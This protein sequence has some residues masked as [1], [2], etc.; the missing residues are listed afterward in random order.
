MEK[1][2]MTAEEFDNFIER[3]VPP[4]EAILRFGIRIENKVFTENFFYI[5]SSIVLSFKNCIF[6]IGFR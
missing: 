3:Q 5:D 2:P 6:K 4:S 1:Q